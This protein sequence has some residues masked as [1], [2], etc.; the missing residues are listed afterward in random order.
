MMKIEFIFSGPLF[1]ISR[2]MGPYK[3]AREND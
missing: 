1:A 3:G 2:R